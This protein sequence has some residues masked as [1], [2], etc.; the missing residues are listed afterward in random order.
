MQYIKESTPIP[1]KGLSAPEG[2]G[3]ESPAFYHAVLTKP[4]RLRHKGP[5]E[6]G[7]R[8]FM[9]HVQFKVLEVLDPCYICMIVS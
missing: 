7:D 1:A 4:L 5:K 9:N 3:L 2:L 8:S 6:I